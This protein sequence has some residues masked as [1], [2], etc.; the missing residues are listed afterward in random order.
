MRTLF[1]AALG[2]VL[3][4]GPAGADDLLADVIQT[5]DRTAAL[6][7]IAD[8]AD[9]A[10]AQSDG[11][12]ALHWA[13]YH[14]DA[15]LTAALLDAGAD[16]DAVNA[17]GS[18]PLAEAVNFLD[19]EIVA[20]LLD[21][22][23]D[24]DA[25]NLDGETVLMA[26]V[27]AG[28]PG[29]VRALLDHG[30]D[31][32]ARE[33]WRD[34]TTLMWAADQA[35][36][37]IVR[38]LLDAGA[39]P[40]VRAAWTDWERQLTS[41]PRAQYRPTGGMTALLYAARSGCAPC[42]AA[43]LDAGA[44]INLPNPDGVTPLMT[45]IDNGGF[46]AAMLLL[47]RGA[48]PRLWDWWGRTALYIVADVSGDEKGGAGPIG[49]VGRS[50]VV[51]E[52]QQASALDLARALIDA[53]ADVNHQL[54]LHRP[55]REGS[56]R[57][58]DDSLRTGCTPLL[59][60][61]IAGD[62]ELSRLLLD[63]GALVD[64]PNVMGV[65][66]LMAAAGLSLSG[67]EVQGDLRSGGAGVQANAI[68]LVDLYLEHGADIDAAVTDTSSWTA[69][70]GR[71]SAVTDRE[72]QTALFGAAGWGWDEVVIHLLARGARADVVDARGKTPVDAARGD[73]GGRLG[74][75]YGGDVS[76]EQSAATIAVLEE[77]MGRL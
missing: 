6:A 27:R 20:L 75:P 7:R 12:T 62:I 59:R 33:A 22:G 26:A 53:G 31:A 24:P 69:R 17:Y 45:A 25:A 74:E 65:T 41:E 46:D 55:D 30:A 8:G 13:A 56:G 36:P 21:G 77:A 19:A 18:R 48:D 23:A 11:T 34:Q 51:V 2:T 10:A 63:H 43:L 58:S 61:A 32:N 54:T 70:I 38:L 68:A 73:W 14:G 67:R 1:A 4:L 5:G 64:L 16:P 57:F 76:A 52:G 3:L 35:Q 37:E 42:V 60:A 40:D 15:E 66:P 39:A 49:G 72:G 28:D 9:V 50:A 29:L 47:S 71:P 44:E